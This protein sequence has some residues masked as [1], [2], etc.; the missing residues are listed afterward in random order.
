MK[1]SLKSILSATL[2]IGAL[3]SCS[4]DKQ[5]I[6]PKVSTLGKGFFVLNQGNYT[7]ANSS[8]SF[9][10]TDSAKM[11]NQVF[12]RANKVP[13]G[14]VA[15]SMT[16]KGN[17]GYL[18]VNNSG[19]IY[20]FKTFDASFAGKIEGFQSPRYICFVQPDKVYVS[21][22]QLPGIH[23]ID[24]VDLQITGFIETGKSVE[25]MLVAD[26]QV[27]ALNW[28]NYYTS[29]NNNTLQVIDPIADRV[30]DSIV[31]AKEPNSMVLDKEGY[32]WVLCSGGFM[33]EEHAALFKINT[34]TLDV[35]TRM[36]FQDIAD[37]PFGLTIDSSGETLY[38]ING[39]VYKLKISDAS[40][41]EEAFVLAGQR[42]FYSL[43]VDPVLKQL[44]VSDVRNYIVNGQVLRFSTDGTIIDSS[45]VGI[46]PGQI[47]FN[48]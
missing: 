27:F 12:Y 1:M 47:V 46:I 43:G 36:N 13:L 40:L 31:L 35:E 42:N 11:T 45:N 5:E 26:E 37:S 34:Q 44:V 3:W 22:L 24:P 41:P 23:I 29:G 32:L 28:S 20:V 18:V 6:N 25:Q 48:Y 17:F 33:N 38:F 10:N 7:L 21:D 19:I 39:D 2:L 8:L 4:D 9:F 30:T 14:D 15:Q 16:V